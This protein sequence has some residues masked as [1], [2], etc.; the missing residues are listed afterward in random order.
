MIQATEQL[1]RSLGLTMACDVL[2]VPR[3]AIYRARQPALI[4][5]WATPIKFISER[6]LSETERAQVRETLNSERFVD[7]APRA[8][9]AT[10]LDE[11][12]YLCSART[13]YRI[14]AENS[15]IRDRR[16]QLRHPNYA[17]PELLAT[18]PNQVWS[19][20]ITKLLGPAKW[21]YFYLY[22]MLDIFSRYVVGWLLADRESSQLAQALMTEACLQQVIPPDQLTIHADRGG[23]MIAKP[24]ALL[25]ADLGVTQ[26]HS[27]PHVSNDNPFSEAQFKTLKYRPDYPKRFGSQLEARTWAREFFPWYNTE[28]RHS[29]VGYFTPAAVHYGTAS[30]IFTDRQR[31]L[32]L[33]YA[34][35]PERFVKGRPVP[36]ALPTAVWIN[37]PKVG[38][39]PIAVVEAG[40][41][42]GNSERSAELSTSPQPQIGAL[43]ANLDSPVRQYIPN[44]VVSNA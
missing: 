10:L 11:E 40:G 8:V 25:L 15:E 12:T 38:A 9:Y 37:P 36:P 28:H 19:W 26:S 13:M 4:S 29:G 32:Q 21:T 18:G 5:A 7:C 31:T 44:Q 30:R 35:H 1:G 23:P 43:I 14:L 33:A 3:S 20:D 16:D 6:A 39:G 41:P 24:V 42:V 17:K 34:A 22:V 2:R 27:R